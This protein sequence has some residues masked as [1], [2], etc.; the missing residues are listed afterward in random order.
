MECI[1]IPT[2]YLP[3]SGSNA[4]YSPAGVH[5]SEGDAT[6]R[7]PAEG[8]WPR[9]LRQWERF[10]RVGILHRHVFPVCGSDPHVH[11]ITQHP[12]S[13]AFW[14]FRSAGWAAFSD[15]RG[16]QRRLRN[17]ASTHPMLSRAIIVAYIR[18]QGCRAWRRGQCK[19]RIDR[20]VHYVVGGTRG[21]QAS[22]KRIRMKPRRMTKTGSH[23]YR[24]G[25]GGERR[26]R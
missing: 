5:G 23:S 15:C 20:R 14:A 10:V 1:Y 17:H 21:S 4:A 13:M 9:L 3:H 22:A 2:W 24:R 19:P 16:R 26:E 7:V 8:P 18:E 11:Q 6:T 12:V 25:G